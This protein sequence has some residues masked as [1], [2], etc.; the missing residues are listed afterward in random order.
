MLKPKTHFEQIPLAIVK[1]I[2]GVPDLH[3]IKT[4]RDR[5]SRKKKPET[6]DRKFPLEFSGGGS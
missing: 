5:V 6:I 4:K 3:G 1:K 2:V